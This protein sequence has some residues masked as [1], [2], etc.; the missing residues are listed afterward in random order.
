MQQLST[1]KMTIGDVISNTHKNHGIA[2]F[3][4]GLPSMLVF[5]TPKA[6][7]RFGSFEFFNGML[8]NPDGTDKYG[9]GSTKGFLAG[10][11]AGAAEAIFV[12]VE[13]FS[14]FI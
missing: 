8:S 1:S 2:G 3:Y 4:R 9:L 6:A 12:S 14:S 7:I 5:A 13:F 11:G 10:L